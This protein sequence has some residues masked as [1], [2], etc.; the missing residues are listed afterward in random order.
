VQ[1]PAQ[2]L[3]LQNIQRAEWLAGCV[4]SRQG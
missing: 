3:L 4:T 2:E 1:W